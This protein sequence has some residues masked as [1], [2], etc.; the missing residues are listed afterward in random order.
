M[1]K[2]LF[3]GTALLILASCGTTANV[4][5]ATKKAG[6]DTL[7]NE[8][9]IVFAGAAQ[10]KNPSMGAYWG[11]AFL[12]I[13]E[14]GLFTYPIQGGA[15]IAGFK[16]ADKSITEELPALQAA[17]IDQFAEDFSSAYRNQFGGSVETISYPFEGKVKL[18]Y[19]SG[20]NTAVKNTISK[21]CAEN[22][23][24]YAVGIITQV[25]HGTSGGQSR[26]IGTQ[27]KT[28][29][30]VFDSNGKIVAQGKT[31]TPMLVVTPSS[32]GDYMQLYAAGEQ[33]TASLISQLVKTR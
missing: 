12:H 16:R 4:V 30:C 8:K 3:L 25:V 17:W 10:R 14:G 7:Q 22:Q 20:A 21:L 28:E 11:Q 19:F 6:M 5:T 32:L 9:V 27:I 26:A 29:V 13:F 1:K 2:F 15:A 23:A 18:T 33:N 31:A 24:K